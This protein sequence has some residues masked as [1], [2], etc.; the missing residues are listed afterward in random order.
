MNKY[1]ILN[2]YSCLGGNRYKYNEVCEKA[3]YECDVTAVEIDSEIANVYKDRFPKDKVI[4]GDAHKTLLDLAENGELEKF[5]FVWS[6]PPCPSHS[7]V[8]VSQKNTD[9]FKPIYPDL[10]LYEEIIFLQNFY[11]GK[12]VVENVTPYYEPL[13]P[14]NKRGRHIYWSNFLL[15]NNLRERKLDGILCRMKNEHQKL[16]IFHDIKVKGNLG[17]YRD[18]LRNLVDYE[19]G[20]TI[21]ETALGIYTRD[22]AKQYELF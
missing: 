21:L 7:T 20:R 19:A 15:P 18:I 12:F 11:N 22:N 4:I 16:E 2:L 10:Q 1:R 3:G 6:S 8:R 5:Q 9:A 14:G 13:I 17:G